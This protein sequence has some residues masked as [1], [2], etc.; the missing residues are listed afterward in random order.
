MAPST[1]HWYW[2]EVPPFT[3]VAVKVTEV[4]VQTGL[5]EAAML[6]LTVCAGFTVITTVFEVSGLPDAQLMLE[7]STHDTWLP[8]VGG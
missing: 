7:V 6:T 2:G 8:L 4:P 1:L 5:A 3:G